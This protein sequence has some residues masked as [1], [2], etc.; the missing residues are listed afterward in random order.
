MDLVSIYAVH[1]QEYVESLN[2]PDSDVEYSV[3]DCPFVSLSLSLSLSL[4]LILSG[5][6]RQR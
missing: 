5:E 6:K 1:A 3:R 2:L 4:T